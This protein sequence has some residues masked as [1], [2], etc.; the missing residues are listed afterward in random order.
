MQIL[1]DSNATLK[2]LTRIVEAELEGE[3]EMLHPLICSEP[4]TEDEAYVKIPIQTRVAW[5]SLFDGERKPTSTEVNIIAQYNKGT[6]ELTMEF[7]SDLVREAKAYTFA[8]KAEE[9]AIS[10]KDFPSY[11]LTQNIIVPNIN[12]YDGKAFYANN[13]LWANAGGNT[14]NNTVPKTG[15]TITALWN[16]FQ[17]AFSQM[18]VFL[19]DKGRKL[20]PRL[21]YG[22]KDLLIQCPS[23]LGPAF[24]QMLNQAFMPV[25]APVTTSGTAAVSASG[26]STISKFAGIASLFVDGYLDAHSPT[27]WY[28]HY[29]GRPQKPFLHTE[30]YPLQFKAL[31]FGTEYESLKNRVAIL[32]KHRWVQGTYRF[33]RSVR[34]A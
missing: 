21:K 1:G 4:S 32:G 28:L 26:P 34:I 5:P 29:V 13:H 6:Y 25:T 11:N 9:G 18:M 31:G 23:A 17:T 15:A 27:T 22:T 14:I 16:D 12:A 3:D 30:S 19:D 2:D 7:D 10:L 20:N 24:H 8:D 33:D